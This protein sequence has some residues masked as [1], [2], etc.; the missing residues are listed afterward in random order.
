MLDSSQNELRRLAALQEC[1]ILDTAP[2][3]AFDS[4]TQLA[5]QICQTPIALVNLMDSERLWVKSKIGT[6]VSE[7]PRKIAFCS[8]AILQGD[9]FIIPDAL[10]DERFSDNPLVTSKPGFRFYAGVPLITLEGYAL[11]TLCLL[12]YVPRQLNSEQIYALKL[13][14][15][16]ATRQLELRQTLADLDHAGITRQLP[17]KKKPFLARIAVGLGMTFAILLGMG[18]GSYQSTNRLIQATHL[19]RHQRNTSNPNNSEALNSSANAEIARVVLE[20]MIGAAVLGSLF[21]SIY[22]ET[23]NRQKTEV[24]LEK[25]HDF[26][27][28]TLNTVDALVVVLDPQGR[29]VRFNR[30]CEIT[31]GYSFDQV[32]YKYFWDFLIPNEQVEAVQS[33]FQGLLIKSPPQAYENHWMTKSGDLRLIDW[34]N[35]VLLNDAGEIEYIIATGIDVTEKRQAEV[36]LRHREEQLQQQN[37]A[38]EQSYTEAEVARKIAEQAASARSTFLAITSHEIRT[39]MNAVLGMTGLLLDTQL[40]AQQRDFAE[41]IRTSGDNLLSLINEILDFSKLEAGEME[42]ELLDFDLLACVEEVTQ[43]LTVFAHQK[44]LEIA[45]VIQPDVSTQLRGDASRVRQILINLLGNAIKFTHSGEVSICVSP[46]TDAETVT[47]LRFSVN[48]TGIGISPKA[49]KKLFQSFTQVDASTTR[50]YGGTGLGLAICKQLVELMGGR[51]GVISAPGQGSQ[52]WFEI[53]LEKQLDAISS[54]SIKPTAD[55]TGLRLLVVDDNAINRKIIRYQ[56]SF[57]GIRVDEA[58]SAKEAL[59]LI[60]SSLQQN[61]LYS[62]AILDMHMPGGNGEML[63]RHIQANSNYDSIQLL[64]MLSLHHQG[65]IKRLRNSGFAGCLVKPV[66]QSRLFSCLVDLVNRPCQKTVSVAI[67]PSKNNS[68]TETTYPS[69]AVHKLKLL[70]VEDNLINQKVAI[71]QLKSLGYNADVVANGKEAVDA[72]Q[73]IR[74][75]LILMDCQTPI[76]DGYEATQSIRHFEKQ[77]PTLKPVTIIAMTANAMQSERDHCLMIGMNDYISKPV[78]KAVLATK[79]AY[80]AEVVSQIKNQSEEDGASLQST[81]SKPVQ[82]CEEGKPFTL[83]ESISLN[84][85]LDLVNWDYLNQ[86]ANNSQESAYQFLAMLVTSLPAHLTTLETAIAEQNY[87]L[88]AQEAHYIKGSSS[89]VGVNPIRF[90]ADTLEQQAQRQLLEQPETIMAEMRLKLQ[91]LTN[92]VRS[93]S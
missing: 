16:Q 63:G 3:E 89:S 59:A 7:I 14:G 22:Y 76:M 52:F 57:W 6:E 54:A 79:L 92:I 67:A 93:N 37:Y 4:I 47:T 42:L 60:E 58:R 23:Q 49:Q 82:S 65:T 36:E 24:L 26:M 8:H 5:R 13:L 83:Q 44:Q 51:I 81:V 80:W 35:A 21:R 46:V 84:A 66:R 90:L 48:D 78:Q 2:E 70:L 75:D 45:A 85:S 86:V 33:I 77:Y 41:T 1:R 28:T 74:Y 73:N 11:G 55:L 12:D 31:T 15:Q 88:I 30:N 40:T 64:M 56:A 50:Q 10:V 91:Q 53:P 43:L 17:S 19:E 27:A 62:I 29:I 69:C 61:S 18:W 9:L 39:P 20:L 32:R 87:S 72:L 25:A 38:L 68:V 71:N 34:S